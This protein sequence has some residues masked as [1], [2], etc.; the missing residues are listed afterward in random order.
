GEPLRALIV[1]GHILDRHGSIL[2]A[3]STLRHPDAADRAG[4]D[5]ALDAGPLGS[6]QQVACTVNVR[7]VQLL[8]ILRPEPVISSHVKDK[9]A[10]LYGPRQR[11]GIAQIAGR[12]LHVQFAD[13]TCGTAQRTDT[14]APF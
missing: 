8:R 2:I 10:S 3:I 14:V 9:L 1:A 4:I 11:F 12:T 5:D 7:A 6:V 13:L